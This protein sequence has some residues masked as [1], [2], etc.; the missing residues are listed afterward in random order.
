MDEDAVFEDGPSI[1]RFRVT[2]LKGLNICPAIDENGA[3]AS[4]EEENGYKVKFVV[5]LFGWLTCQDKHL[6]KYAALYHEHFACKVV[7]RYTVP[8]G[9]VL[10]RKQ[11]EVVR[12]AEDIMSLIPLFFPRAKVLVHYFS[13][14]GCF[15]HRRLLLLLNGHYRQR[16]RRFCCDRRPP[17]EEHSF[18][19]LAATIFDSCPAAADAQTGAKALSAALRVSNLN[20]YRR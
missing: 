18:S 19:Q 12:T 3:S 1:G 20:V 2:K 6:R 5:L 16:S 7:L 15:V 9:N 4:S 17:N 14:G 13:N 10:R 8:A 11:S